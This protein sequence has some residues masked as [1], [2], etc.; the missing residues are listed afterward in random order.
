VTIPW[1]FP[2]RTRHLQRLVSNS[3]VPVVLPNGDALVITTSQLADAK[4]QLIVGKIAPDELIA[5]SDAALG[6]A[7]DWLR[8]RCAGPR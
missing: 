5:A 3:G 4:G 6:A 8:Q 1:G 2:I 7:T